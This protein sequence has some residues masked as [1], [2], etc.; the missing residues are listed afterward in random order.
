M[1]HK[2]ANSLLTGP[3]NGAPFLFRL[4]LIKITVQVVGYRHNFSV[5]VTRRRDK[6]NLADR[7]DNSIDPGSYV[8][9]AEP[10]QT[11]P[12]AYGFHFC[13]WFGDASQ[14]SDLTD[15]NSFNSGAVFIEASATT[16]AAI[17]YSSARTASS[18]D[19]PVSLIQLCLIRICSMVASNLYKAYYLV[20]DIV[21]TVSTE[22]YDICEP[23][24]KHIA[25][26]KQRSIG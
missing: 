5:C 15:N 19:S 6:I 9:T 16:S 13:L 18:M 22:L 17:E 21:G 26:Y 14:S 24:R 8:W 3:Q 2:A 10:L 1:S 20:D 12:I 23:L 11:L 25:R 4:L 7:I